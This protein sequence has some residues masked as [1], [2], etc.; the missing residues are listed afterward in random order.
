[1]STLIQEGHFSTCLNAFL[2]RDGFKDVLKC[3]TELELQFE[4]KSPEQYTLAQIL[5]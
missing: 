4:D 2:N 1:M 5:P 3:F